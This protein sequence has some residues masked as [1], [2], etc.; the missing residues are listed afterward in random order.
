MSQK[1]IFFSKLSSD[2]LF[3][4]LKFFCLFFNLHSFREM[5]KLKKIPQKSNR[6]LRDG[7]WVLGLSTSWPWKDKT[8][9][10]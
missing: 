5:Q 4:T 7:K 1:G 3:P 8:E 2:Y 6:Q 9:S 10:P